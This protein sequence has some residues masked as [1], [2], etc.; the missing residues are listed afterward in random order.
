MFFF[1][2]INIFSI[3]LYL[4]GMAKLKEKNSVMPKS[5]LSS[6]LLIF[7]FVTGMVVYLYNYNVPAKQDFFRTL[8]VLLSFFGLIFS[9]ARFSLALDFSKNADGWIYSATLLAQSFTQIL[10]LDGSTL[11]Q[12][13]RTNNADEDN[14]KKRVDKVIIPIIYISFTIF[15]LGV[16][17]PYLANI[18]EWHFGASDIL[19]SSVIAFLLGIL[20][21]FLIPF[22]IR[23]K[24]LHYFATSMFAI[25]I[26]MYLQNNFM[27]GKLFL[28]GDY[29][30]STW[31]RIIVNCFVWIGILAVSVIIVNKNNAKQ[32]LKIQ[33][34]VL[35]IILLMQL[36]II[37]YL[38]LSMAH[39]DNSAKLDLDG[40]GQFSVGKDKNIIV[41]I[42]DTF[43]SGYFDSFLENNPEYYEKLSDFIYFDNMNSEEDNTALSM[44]Y[45]L[46]AHDNDFTISLPTSN[47]NS[48]NSEEAS[49]F[50]DTLHR[51]GFVVELYTDNALYSGGASNMLGKVDNIITLEGE[52]KASTLSA[53]IYTYCG[54]LK[55]SLFRVTPFIVKNYFC[56][57]DS[58]EINKYIYDDDM[59]SGSD[60]WLEITMSSKERGIMHYNDDFYEKLTEGI[61]VNDVDNKLIFYHLF[62]MHKPFSLAKNESSQASY[63]DQAVEGCMY[64]LLDYIN[65]L[66]ELDLYD[67]S[68]I[69]LT[70]DHG[71]Q[72][73]N[74][75]QPILLIKQKNYHSDKM[76][77]N[78]APG[79][80]QADLLPTILF[81]N[82]DSISSCYSGYSLLSMDENAQRERI[83][84]ICDTNPFFL[85]AKKCNGAGTSIINCYKEYHYT[86][87]LDDIDFDDLECNI[88]PI[89]SYWW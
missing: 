84:R 18:D 22:V 89:T 46:T 67:D 3:I 68:V 26:L 11:L 10:T 59:F 75:N 72:T 88:Y 87:R 53:K 2:I 28:R 16:W 55:V 70:A 57:L 29:V 13:I 30:I 79:S 83:I 61:S 35:I 58:N 7:V 80:I 33:K 48:W 52:E 60:D 69:I 41:F 34:I 51:D 64:I 43:Y 15:V 12:Q 23:G 17:E 65:Q 21:A 5:I 77:I 76:T 86:G 20:P 37:P 49:Y 31:P 54:M 73:L 14:Y 66:K 40:S 50:Y 45:L 32:V 36:P 19:F 25:C 71:T 27:N 39:N 85:D 44:P 62:G 24:N 78:G 47:Y 1:I 9:Y 56:V 38:S 6:L 4:I 74:T 42:M 82:D 81:C 8:I 63:D